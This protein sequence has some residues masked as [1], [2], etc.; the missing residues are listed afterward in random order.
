MHDNQLIDESAL[1]QAEVVGSILI[2]FSVR[3]F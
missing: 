1:S 2:N 3:S